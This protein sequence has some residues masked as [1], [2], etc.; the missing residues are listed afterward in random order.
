MSSKA[1]W[2][3]WAWLAFVAF[4]NQAWHPY[5]TEL[6]RVPGLRGYHDV[7]RHP[8]AERIDGILILRFDAPLFFANGGMFDD[9]V[10]S[11]VVDAQRSGR[12]IA[13]VIL[14]AEPSPRSMRPPS[15]NSWNSTITFSPRA[16]R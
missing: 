3:P 13:T 2:W 4:V 16:S 7:T 5:R 11:K 1:F 8:D 12:A 15:T 9:Y 14:A 10:R 6:G